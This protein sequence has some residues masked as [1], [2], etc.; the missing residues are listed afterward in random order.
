MKLAPTLFASSFVLSVAA[1]LVRLDAG[2][3]ADGP[4]RKPVLGVATIDGHKLSVSLDRDRVPIGEPVK[5]AIAATD[6]SHGEKLRVA[7]LEQ[8]GSPEMRSMPP[9]REV[10]HQ[11]VVLGDEPLTLPITLAGPPLPAGAQAPDP[12]TQAG[13]ATQFTVVVTAAVPDAGKGNRPRDAGAYL[14]VFAYHPDAYRL[15]LQPLAAG[16]PGD[17]IDVAVEVTSLVDR[18]LTG[19]GIGLSSELVAID[20]SAKLDTL[21][22][23]ARTIVHLHGHRQQVAGGPVLV[24]AYGFAVLGG[25]AAAWARV[26]PAAGTLLAQSSQPLEP[27]PAIG[28]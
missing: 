5:L 10:S 16:K 2:P 9:P 12:L 26:D 4:A 23:H 13:Q 20:D 27:D 19:L 22:P 18:P 24:Q 28:L 7:V 17:A 6:G 14:P 21:A 15:K 25:T 1:G 3:D 8:V 11:D